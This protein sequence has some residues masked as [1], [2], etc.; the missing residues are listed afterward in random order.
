MAT[1]LPLKWWQSEDSDFRVIISISYGVRLKFRK[2][3]GLFG[4]KNNV[5]Q[6]THKIAT[7]RRHNKDTDRAIF[8]CLSVDEFHFT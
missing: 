2:K 7:E 1:A 3:I 6:N 5:D 8:D 4:N